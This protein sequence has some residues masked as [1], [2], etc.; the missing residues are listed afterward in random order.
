MIDYFM[1]LYYNDSSKRKKDGHYMYK[2]VQHIIAK[3]E[4]KMPIN[5]SDVD[6]FVDN[7]FI[8]IR[9]KTDVATLDKMEDEHSDEVY[10][11]EDNEIKNKFF[12]LDK[13]INEETIRIDYRYTSDLLEQLFKK[14]ELPIIVTPA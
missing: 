13:K 5:L 14:L 6:I 9:N 12:F 4:A 2:A 11:N 1:E 3:K 10:S 7:D 8:E